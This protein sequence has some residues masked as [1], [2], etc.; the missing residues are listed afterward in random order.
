ME[1]IAEFN[2]VMKEHLWRIQW[3]EIKRHYLGH[4]IQNELIELLANGVRNTIIRKVK[5]MKY[6]KIILNCTPDISHQEQMTLI[7]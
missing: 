3:K 2:L 7:L 1:L 5:Q 6:F 4:N